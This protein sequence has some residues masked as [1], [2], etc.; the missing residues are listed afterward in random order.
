MALAIRIIIPHVGLPFNIQH[1]FLLPIR[2][3][4][5]CVVH[6]VLVYSVARVR[7]SGPAIIV[8]VCNYR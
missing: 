3:M 1:I 2:C 6:A 4:H 8:Q 5:V 7:V